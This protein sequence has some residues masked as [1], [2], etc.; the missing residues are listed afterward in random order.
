MLKKEKLIFISLFF[1]LIFSF[2]ISYLVIEDKTFSYIENR[3]L[4][5]FPKLNYETILNGTFMRDFENYANDQVVLRDNFVKLSTNTRIWMGQKDIN[6]IILGKDGYLIKKITNVE[7][8]KE[9]IEKNIEHIRTFLKKY[10]NSYFAL[11][12]TA[13]DILKGYYIDYPDRLNQKEFIDNVY[14]NVSIES[15]KVIDIYSYLD[16]KDSIYYKTDHHWTTYGAYQGYLAICNKLR[17]EPIGIEEYTKEIVC[18]DFYGTI[19]SELNLKKSVDII[20]KYVPK[21]SVEY[22]RVLNEMES[23]SGL[24]DDTKLKTKERY[25]YF[26][27]GNQ[28]IT[29]IKTNLNTGRSILIVKDSFSHSLV[30]FLV[31]H[32]DRVT[33]V[34]LR[35]FNGYFSYFM[36]SPKYSDYDDILVMYNI[37][38][39]NSERKFSLLNK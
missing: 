24:Y 4:Q 39:F 35:Y 34:D 37:S 12:P 1:I 29:D 25:A 16:G 23:F 13:S 27:G 31:N 38:N 19:D 2:F 7:M 32:Y 9:G 36:N 17:L 33:L 3:K 28:A 10:E 14:S 15:S 20:Y 26:L 11:I 6:G 5:V 30:P 22:T 21:F 8:D 18:D